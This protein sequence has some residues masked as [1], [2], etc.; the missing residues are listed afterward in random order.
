MQEKPRFYKEF[1]TQRRVQK[2][3]GLIN[4]ELAI[5]YALVLDDA[6]DLIVQPGRAQPHNGGLNCS[7]LLAIVDYEKP[8][9]SVVIMISMTNSSSLTKMAMSST[10]PADLRQAVKKS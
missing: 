3:T 8:T 7:L 9:F 6:F 4:G 5:G 2:S 1:A 10:T